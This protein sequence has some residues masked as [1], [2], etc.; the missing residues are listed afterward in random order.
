[1]GITSLQEIRNMQIGRI[2]EL[3]IEAWDNK[4]FYT[5]PISAVKQAEVQYWSAP[6]KLKEVGSDIEVKKLVL[7]NTVCDDKGNL[8]FDKKTIDELMKCDA[9][10]VNQLYQFVIMRDFLKAKDLDALAKK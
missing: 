8:L 1:M 2:D 3:E 9:L 4:V 6:E 5:K 10:V 7:M